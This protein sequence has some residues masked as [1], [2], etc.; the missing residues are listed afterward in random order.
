MCGIGG[1]SLARGSRINPRKLSNAL[2]TGLEAR[3]SQASGFAWQANKGSGFY[4]QDTAGSRLSLRSMPSNTHTAILHTRLATHGTIKDNAN[5]HPVMSPD[6][7]IALVH[8]GVIYNHARVRQELPYK[9]PEV[10]TSVI[11]A[12]LQKYGYERFDM[13]DGDASVAWLDQ[14]V[15]GRLNVGRFSHS[16]LWI[17]QV[18]DGSFIFASTESILV[19]AL[20][21]LRLKADFI[22]E[23]PE[24]ALYTVVAG[25]LTDTVTL[26]LSS[27]DYQEK[28]SASSYSK[29]RHMTSGYKWSDYQDGVCETDPY[30][31]DDEDFDFEEFL[32]NYVE[33][34]GFFYTYDGGLLGDKNSMYEIYEDNRYRRYWE[35]SDELNLDEQ[36][37]EDY[38]LSFEDWSYKN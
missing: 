35:K 36:A 18:T 10:D 14:S 27:P 29:Y 4:K 12:I 16:P 25:I 5:N 24:R 1:F 17:C 26:P 30:Y 11:P 21:R 32:W 23:T 19:T 9:L 7:K 38:R 13:L 20:K 15:S 34:D 28:Q 3:G 6:Q 33:I 22:Q 31:G 37:Q 2:L 8:N